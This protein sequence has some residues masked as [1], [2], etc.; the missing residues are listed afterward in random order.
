[1]IAVTV[2]VGGLSLST[3]HAAPID[4]YGNL[5]TVNTTTTSNTV[6]YLSNAQTNQYQAQGFSVG[7]QVGNTAWNIE[8][9]D[10]G[11]GSTGSPSPVMQIYSNSAG[12]P[13]SV[14]AS[15]TTG[16]AVSAKQVY[17]F[18][19]SFV[20]QE[21]TSY[22]VVL[23]NANSASQESYEWYSNDAFSAPSTNNA[24]G[25]SYL[26]TKESNNLASWV[27][28]LQSLSIA[29]YAESTTTAVPEIDPSSFGS[30]L[31]LVAGSLG[32]LERR[33]RRLLGLTA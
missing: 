9:I 1:M 2:A 31:A 17:S 21:N 13:G 24:S 22:W 26:G 28:T 25:V 29:L 6:G 7:R 16:S 3:V 23:S 15:F 30:A 32:L 19:G 20:A 27:N 8:K 14:L 5:G 10:V 12:A 33:A 18:T 4:I 11:L